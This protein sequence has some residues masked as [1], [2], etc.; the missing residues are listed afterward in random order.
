MCACGKGEGVLCCTRAGAMCLLQRFACPV[1]RCC[2]AGKD[3]ADQV[4]ET[5]GLAPAL[6]AVLNATLPST[7]G[8]MQL[9]SFAWTQRMGREDAPCDA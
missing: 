7:N 4:A 6:K 2:Q 3:V 5:D 8:G 1:C 9:P